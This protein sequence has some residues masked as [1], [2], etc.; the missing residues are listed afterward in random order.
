MCA[1]AGRWICYSANRESTTADRARVRSSWNQRPSP[2]HALKGR[3]Q[4]VSL[5]V[6]IGDG[7]LSLSTDRPD[8]LD[9]IVGEDT[10]RPQPVPRHER[11]RFS[12]PGRASPEEQMAQEGDR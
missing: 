6:T 12:G 11:E 9:R 8:F 4:A 1:V 7:S 10:D 3:L 2:T 5:S